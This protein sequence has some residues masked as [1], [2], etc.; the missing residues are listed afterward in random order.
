MISDYL[1]TQDLDK[2]LAELREKKIS[3][4]GFD[5]SSKDLLDTLTK[6]SEEIP[7]WEDGVTFIPDSE[8]VE[9]VQAMVEGT[10]GVYTNLPRYVVINWEAS[11]AQVQEGYTYVEYDGVAY[12]YN[13]SR[14]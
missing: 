11:A 1:T 13:D 8:W 9:Y 4:E 6:M 7:D 10:N 14:K 12:W 2:T 5:S 3:G